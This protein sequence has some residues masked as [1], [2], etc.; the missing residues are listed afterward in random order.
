MGPLDCMQSLCL[1]VPRRWDWRGLVSG[2]GLPPAAKVYGS[3]DSQS[4]L[5]GSH[6]W[7]PLPV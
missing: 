7:S 1:L 6:C 2:H 4:V 3:W 5:G